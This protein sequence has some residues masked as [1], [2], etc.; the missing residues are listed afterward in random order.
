VGP[1]QHKSYREKPTQRLKGCPICGTHRQLE[2]NPRKNKTHQATQKN[3]PRAVDQEAPCIRFGANCQAR[4]GNIKQE[5]KEMVEPSHVYCP[6]MRTLASFGLAFH[7]LAIRTLTPLFK[8][9]AITKVWGMSTG[10]G[11]FKGVK[12]R[13]AYVGTSNSDLKTFDRALSGQAGKTTRSK[14][15]TRIIFGGATT[16]AFNEFAN[17]KQ[18]DRRKDKILNGMRGLLHVS[19]Y[20]YPQARKTTLS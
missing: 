14:E 6:S 1:E 9:Y 18:H 12:T 20:G 2:L 17:L 11:E 15:G 10:C 7:P 19:V 5:T 13:N 16:R 8:P 4:D 3:N